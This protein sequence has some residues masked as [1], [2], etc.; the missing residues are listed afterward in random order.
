[1]SDWSASAFFCCCVTEVPVFCGTTNKITLTGLKE[2][3]TST[4]VS[5]A[6]CH[7]LQIRTNAPNR[8]GAVGTVPT[9]RQQTPPRPRPAATVTTKDLGSC[10]DLTDDDEKAPAATTVTKS[11]TAKSGMTTPVR[12]VVGTNAIFTPTGAAALKSGAVIFKGTPTSLGGP[13]VLQPVTQAIRLSA[14]Q[15]AL[16]M[17]ATRAP[18]GVRPVAT[19]AAVKPGQILL[20]PRITTTAVTRPPPPLKS[21]PSLVSVFG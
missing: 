19:A 21:V 10:I 2:T 9:V 4:S 5:D 16:M 6:S 8:G 18:G 15:G 11:A 3:F 17:A 13:L 20:Q 7:C 12:S 14:Q 1:M